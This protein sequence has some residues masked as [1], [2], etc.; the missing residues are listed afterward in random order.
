MFTE[1]QQFSFSKRP[2]KMPSTYRSHRASDNTFLS[3]YVL[4]RLATAGVEDNPIRDDYWY[5]IHGEKVHYKILFF[6]ICSSVVCKN[7]NFVDKNFVPIPVWF[8][9]ELVSH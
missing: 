1:F 2:T 3:K 6:I 8:P 9:I 5:W 4:N 7:F